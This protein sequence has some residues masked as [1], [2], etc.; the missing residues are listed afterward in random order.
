MDPVLLARI[1][2]GFTVGFHFLFPPLTFGLTLVILILETLY[3]RTDKPLYREAST[4]WIKLLGLTFAVGVATGITM[5]FAFGTNWSEYS[6]FVGDIFG[7]PLAAEGIFAFFLESS[8]LGVLLFGRK[9]VSKKVYWLA[10]FLVFFASH[11][12]GLWILIANSWQQ[13]PAGY[14]I[15]GGRAQLT[16]FWAAVFNPS[17]VPRFLHT[18]AAGWI[19]GAFFV[20]G[21]SAWYLLRGRHREFALLSFRIAVVIGLVVGVTQ[22]LLGH[23]HSVQVA[24]TQPA[25]MAALE[26]LFQTTRGAPLAIFGIPDVAQRTVHLYLGVPKLLSF[27]VHFDP[28]AEILGLDAFPEADWPPVP[29]VFQSY[30]LMVALGVYFALV[31]LLGAYLYRTGRLERTRWYLKVLLVSIP[32]PQLANQAGWVSAEVGRQPWVVYGVLRTADAVS[33]TVPAGQVLFTLLMFAAIYAL[34]FAM[35]LSLLLREVRH[36]PPSLREARAEAAPVEGQGG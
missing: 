4:F 36:G 18:V 8:F 10:A 16:D 25:K 34:L 5:E 11:L 28:N 21:I 9:R 20:A 19:T 27:L 13:T 22:G 24:L 33:V 31:M 15:V 2:F 6:R 35:Y 29:V 32:L 17:T 14:E 23:N 3:L 7:A 30:R 12:S 26:G 1:Q